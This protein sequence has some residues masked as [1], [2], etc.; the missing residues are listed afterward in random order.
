MKCR[1]LTCVIARGES[2]ISYLHALH[3]PFVCSLR[4]FPEILVLYL[5]Y[6]EGD[7]ELAQ[8]SLES[9]I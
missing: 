3:P 4:G 1:M 8:E 5:P 7:I 9:D 2:F 6:I